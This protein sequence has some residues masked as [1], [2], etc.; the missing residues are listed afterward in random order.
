VPLQLA[1]ICRN[2]DINSYSSSYSSNGSSYSSSGSSSSGGSDNRVNA[3]CIAAWAWKALVVFL[4]S[5]LMTLMPNGTIAEPRAVSTS[6]QSAITAQLQQSGLLQQFPSILLTAAQLLKDAATTAGASGYCA[7]A[8]ASHG[9]PA[10]AAA[11]ASSSRG[12]IGGDSKAFDNL[13]LLSA[14]L[15]IAV[16]MLGC[17]QPQ[18]EPMPETARRLDAAACFCLAIMQLVTAALDSVPAEPTA[19]VMLGDIYRSPLC[20]AFDAMVWVVQAVQTSPYEQLVQLLQSSNIRAAVS[21]VACIWYARTLMPSMSGRVSN[22]SIAAVAAAA[23]AAAA[24]AQRQG[25]FDWQAAAMFCS[26][27]VPPVQQQ[28]QQQHFKPSL[29]ATGVSIHA[30]AWAAAWMGSTEAKHAAVMIVHSMSAIVRWFARQHNDINQQQLPRWQQLQQKK[31]IGS[32]AQLVAQQAEHNLLLLQLLLCST[33]QQPDLLGSGLE[34]CAAELTQATFATFYHFPE[35]YMTAAMTGI[36]QGP[37]SRSSTA[38]TS[39]AAA[40]AVAA[41]MAAENA[42]AKAT[43]LLY[44]WSTC[45][46]PTLVALLQRTQQRVPSRRTALAALS[47]PYSI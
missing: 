29:G 14:Q 45:M 33:D 40:A 18:D 13:L 47:T 25:Q 8:G 15:A 24:T 44:G 37:S 9:Q 39:P 26:Q 2:L 42:L 1:T 10:A 28:Q 20:Q 12:S 19:P 3:L 22:N 30:A 46:L 36:R 38:G 17:F 32:A 41:A 34:H 35:C 16:H 31:C 27:L 21:A 7:P 6:L 11:R 4:A 5:A 43:E 23:A